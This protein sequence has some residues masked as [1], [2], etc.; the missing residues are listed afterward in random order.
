MSREGLEVAD[1]AG[2]RIVVVH[3]SL[4]EEYFPAVVLRERV[5]TIGVG[6]GEDSYQ[7]SYVLGAVL[8]RGGIQVADQPSREIRRFD[9]RGSFLASVG[10]EGEGP[11]EFESLSWIQQGPGG[12]LFAWDGR[13]SRLT[14]IA[15]GDSALS[16]TA[17]GST[18]ANDCGLA[19]IYVPRL[20]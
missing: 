4:R 5:D 12:L 10:G 19:D 15:I 3:D 20:R 11:G 2:V 18:M 16:S 6:L 9:G 1:S 17:S 8:T 7:F 13:A 14:R